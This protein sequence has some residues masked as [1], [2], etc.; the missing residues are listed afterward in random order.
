MI[1]ELFKF[2]QTPEYFHGLIITLTGIAI[3]LLFLLIAIPIIVHII[4]K[5][6]TRPIRANIDFYLFQFFHRITRMFLS[7][8]SFNYFQDYDSIL[9]N[10]QKKNPNFKI[11]SHRIYGNL[12]NIIFVLRTIFADGRF[13]QELRKRTLDDFQE[14]AS[15]CEKCMDEIDRLAA[16]LVVL[17]KVQQ[18][19]FEFRMVVY[20]LRDF[21][22]DEIRVFKSTAEGT[23]PSHD[24]YTLQQLAKGIVEIIDKTF[25]ERRKLIDS[26]MKRSIRR[27]E[28][29]SW[30]K[31]PSLGPQLP[32]YIWFLLKLHW[33]ITRP[34][35]KQNKKGTN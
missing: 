22:Y 6:R 23:Q 17:P 16:I 15:I 34:W 29:R 31:P 1:D 19:L 9:S 11:L 30:F 7:M 13:A 2:V 10:E 21:I 5:I 3:E 26:M 27:Y 33:S 24:Y 28:G 8:A 4:R 12:E 20:P 18:A 35:K 25:Q 14:Y 32:G